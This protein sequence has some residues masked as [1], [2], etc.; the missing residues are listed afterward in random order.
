MNKKQDVKKY[1]SAPIFLTSQSQKE[2]DEMNDD[3]KKSV[4]ANL[5]LYTEKLEVKMAI[6]VLACSINDLIKRIEKLETPND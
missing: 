1:G 6:D 5:S 2:W 3:V 4:L